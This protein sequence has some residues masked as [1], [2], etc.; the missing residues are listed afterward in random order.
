MQLTF[1]GTGQPALRPLAPRRFE[2]G[3]GAWVDHQPG[4]VD[5]H[6]EVYALLRD[7]LRWRV[8]QR[9][10]YERVVDVPRL[11]ASVPADGALPP[12]LL[13]AAAA[14][15]ARY[16][17]VFDHAHL[18]Y[19][20]DGRDSVAWHA[21]RLESPSET[22]EVGIVSFGEPRG[23]LIRPRGGRALKFRLGW[24]D[25]LV[26]GGACQAMC[27]HAVP[28]TREAQPRISVMLRHG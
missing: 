14:L 19:Y 10:M 1:L 5:G 7:T 21:D 6:A 11:V 25:L 23:F 17:R 28:K 18:A 26:M 4:W 13:S 9:E 27:E 24:G 16:G 12:L 20:R 15:G 22:A 8:Q 3:G 2:L